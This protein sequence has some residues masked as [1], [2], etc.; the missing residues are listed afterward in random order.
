MYIIEDGIAYQINGDVACQVNFD[1]DGSLLVNK[2]KTIKIEGKEKYTYNEMYAKL[3]VAYMIE[4]KKKENALK[5][6]N[7]EQIKKLNSKIEELTKENKELK[8]K[9]AKKEEK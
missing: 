2:D 4:E 9:L 1:I 6:S 5:G 8:D 7:N 3:N